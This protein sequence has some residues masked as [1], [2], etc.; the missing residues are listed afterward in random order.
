MDSDLKKCEKI[1][2]LFSGFI[3]CNEEMAVTYVEGYG[4]IVLDLFDGEQFDE[5][6][7]FTQ[8]SPMFNTLLNDW[9]YVTL[10][11]ILKPQGIL[12]KAD[13]Y[14]YESVKQYLTKKQRAAFVS[15]QKKYLSS[16][17]K[18]MGQA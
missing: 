8:P 2:E 10:N 18:L 9:E 14:G 12:K 13:N 6:L 7:L 5:C 11:E 3:A 4:Y 16:Y 15:Q 1:Q 17:K